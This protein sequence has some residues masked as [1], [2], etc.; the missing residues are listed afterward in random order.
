VQLEACARLMLDRKYAV[1][2]HFVLSAVEVIPILLFMVLAYALKTRW[3]GLSL[4]F[5]P[6]SKTSLAQPPV[7][8]S[9]DPPIE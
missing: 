2:F 3:G 6:V 8:I 5:C 7:V 1:E 4:P 9:S